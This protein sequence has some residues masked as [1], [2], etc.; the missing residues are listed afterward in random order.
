MLSSGAWSIRCSIQVKLM[1]IERLASSD[2]ER[3]IVDHLHCGRRSCWARWRVAICDASTGLLKVLEIKL[4]RCD[5]GALGWLLVLRRAI[6]AMNG[7]GQTVP[8]GVAQGRVKGRKAKPDLGHRV[9]SPP[10][11]PISGSMNGAVRRS[12]LS[13]QP[14]VPALPEVVAER[15]GLKMRAT[16]SSGNDERPIASRV[17]R[18]SFAGEA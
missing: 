9:S 17:R 15:D 5:V 6:R 16:A 11:Q 12:N 8:F 10:V 3:P 1:R 7:V 14:F 18:L 13:R 4:L 2:R